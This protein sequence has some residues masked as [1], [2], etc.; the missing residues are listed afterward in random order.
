MRAGTKAGTR[1]RPRPPR[2]SPSTT[3]RRSSPGSPPL[4]RH[5]P[6]K[7]LSRRQGAERMAADFLVVVADFLED[8][9]VESPILGDI[10]QIKLAGARDEPEL[11]RH[12]AD[13]DA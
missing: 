11:V 8:D 5:T 12:V 6:T 7:P 1:T 2:R 9:A 10:A 3:P 13:A 4:E